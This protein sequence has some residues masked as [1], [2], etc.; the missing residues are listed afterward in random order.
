MVIKVDKR[1]DVIK[2]KSKQNKTIQ[3][4]T[5]YFDIEQNLASDF[6]LIAEKKIMIVFQNTSIQI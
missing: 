5:I 3:Y 2:H 6:I 1:I 4:N